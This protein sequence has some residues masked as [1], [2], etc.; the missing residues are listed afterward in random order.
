MKLGIAA[1]YDVRNPR[2]WSGTPFSLWSAL[3]RFDDAE[4]D[5]INLSDYYTFFNQR[6]HY[7]QSTDWKASFKKK[8][9]V[10][11]YGVSE[12]NPLHSRL[13]EKH[14]AH[15]QYDAVLEMGGYRTGKLMPARY[16]YSD[17]THDMALDFYEKSGELPYP[18]KA[19]DLDVVKR[20]AEYC[21]DMYLQSDG[22]FCM[23]RW[24]REN[25]IRATGVDADKTHTVYAAANWH[26]VDIKDLF[27]PKSIHGKKR[28][29]I[30]VVGV[31]FRGKGVDII[32]RALKVL[33]NESSTEYFLHV[34]GLNDDKELSGNSH[35]INHGFLDKARL[36]ALLN[37]C[38]I[39]VLPSRFD[40]FGIAFIEAMS[41]GL[42]CIGR[43]ICAMPEIIDAGINGELVD[44]DDETKLAALIDKI[45][46]NEEQY[47]RFS[48]N[49]IIK[50][51]TYSWERIAEQMLATM[52]ERAIYPSRVSSDKPE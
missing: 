42:P 50:A 8:A 28:F 52:K 44:G 10:S 18:Y 19:E 43:N 33:N 15:H 27:H 3:K 30:V 31:T 41:C 14:C 1:P 26:G 36:V 21:R 29:N 51:K 49:A 40:Y 34:A 5:C 23:S 13:L 11:K 7:I 12:L 35:V 38:D 47:L 46:S 17:S 2:S 37:E 4:I 45:C 32:I 25:L 16:I 39:F 48:K 24:M 6:L 20:A 9:R 22:I